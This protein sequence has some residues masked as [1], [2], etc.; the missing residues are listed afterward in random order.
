MNANK[1]GHRI[2]VARTMQKP[3]LTQDD[4][5]AQLQIAGLEI[6]KNILSRIETGE[7]YVTDLELLVFSKVLKVSTAWL[8]EET[9]DPN[10]KK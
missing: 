9:N 2:R 6:S 3:R 7:R 8:L 10:M 5:V 4:L 1:S